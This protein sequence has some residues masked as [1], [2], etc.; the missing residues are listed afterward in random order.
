MSEGVTIWGLHTMATSCRHD[1]SRFNET[2]EGCESS[3][4]AH[5]DDPVYFTWDMLKGLKP[6]ALDG[7]RTIPP[8]DEWPP[9]MRYLQEIPPTT[10]SPPEMN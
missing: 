1:E 3:G 7:L 9:E 6:G 10:Y 2:D 5:M 4:P 8:R